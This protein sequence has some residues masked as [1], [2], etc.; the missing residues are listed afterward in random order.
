MDKERER[1]QADLRGL[2]EGDARCDDVFVQMYASDASIF[3]LRPLAVVRPKSVDDVS[4]V[5]KYAAERGIPI[6]ARGA[7]TGVAGESLGNG[8]VIDFSHSMRRVI[9]IDEHTARVQPGVVHANLN[10]HLARRGRLFGPDPATRSVTTMG[11]VLALDGSGSHWL[12]YGSARSRVKSM[13][14]VLADGEIMEVNKHLIG[15]PAEAAAAPRRSELVQRL[16]DLI[17]RHADTIRNQQPK[18]LVNR[19]GYHLN[20][21]VEQGQLDLARLLVGSE[22]TLALITEATVIT[23]PLPLHR[24]VA[25]FFFERLDLAARGA[26]E[27][28]NL[29]ISACDLMDRRLLTIA[30]EANPRFEALIPRGCEALLLIELQDDSES[31]LRARIQNLVNRLQRR[32]RLAFDSR[33]T[34]DREERNLYWRLT[35]RV[36]PTLY[37][38]KGSTRPLPFIEDIAVPPAQLPDFLVTLQN[39]LKAHQVTA[40]LFAH[41]AHG[42]LHVRPFLDLAN[43]DNVRK[44]QGL[45][46]DLY[47]EVLRVGGTISGEHGDGLSRTWYARR[48]HGPLYDVFRDVKRVFDPQSILNPGKVVADAPQPLAKNLRPVTA[49]EAEKSSDLEEPVPVDDLPAPS[50]AARLPL[51]LVWEEGELPYA[52]RNCNGCGR[53]RT[54][55]TVER[56]CPVFR[57][58]PSEEAAPRSK[59]NL[60]RAVLTGELDRDHLTSDAFKAVADLCV[61]CHQCRLECP[62]GVD[63]PKLAVEAKGQY[64]AVNGLSLTDSWMTRLDTIAK[65]CSLSSPAANWALSSPTMRWMIEKLF[66]VAQGRKLPRFAARSFMRLAQRRRLTRPTRRTD[67]KVLYFVDLYANWFDVQ[68]AEAFTAVLEHNGVAVYVHPRQ[69]PAGMQSIA[70]GAVDRAKRLAARNVSL[71]ADAVRQGY[72]IASTEPSAALCLKREYPQLIDDDDARLVADNSSEACEYLMQLHR[73]G[74]L[75]LDLR[76][77]NITVGYHQPCHVR[78]L[79]EPRL[80]GLPETS[81][82]ESLMRLIPGLNVRTIDRGCSGM[83]GLWGIKRQN[84]RSSLRSGW[85]LISALRDPLLT[86]GA[87]ECSCCKIQMEQGVSKPTVHPLKLL[88]LAYNLMPELDD[89]LT[90]RSNELLTS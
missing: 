19:S 83:A 62:A 84:Y 24:G 77:M 54:Q 1:I 31:D 23:D 8:I 5:V 10:R 33:S 12:K 69:S 75:E 64:V 2:I 41:A 57:L 82:G 78:A 29:D 81:A 79:A 61:H 36:V 87:T 58:A 16:T 15:D 34:L 25:L 47:D 20:D 68:L 45:A 55:S 7:G 37:R 89:L 63:I 60:L 74:R 32:K 73:E 6:H 65:W 11:S 40:S 3:E 59:A 66:G 4:A 21:V 51:Q 39:V 52:A 70:V 35:R 38:L 27:A 50:P 88:A 90:A 44:M 85:G 48:Q 9:S 67:R 86:V 26:L 72:H 13:Q 22:G 46:A 42:Q 17:M 53:C 30:R 80:G 76:P 71:L 49:Y 56:M 43:P 28:A 18:S 14:V